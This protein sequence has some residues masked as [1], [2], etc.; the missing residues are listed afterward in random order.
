[1]VQWVLSLHFWYWN[2]DF[3]RLCLTYKCSLC[4]NGSKFQQP[5]F[6][7]KW[8]TKMKYQWTWWSCHFWYGLVYICCLYVCACA[9]AFMNH[10]RI[11]PC[12]VG[13]VTSLW[14]MLLK[15][16]GVSRPDSLM[17][18]IKLIAYKKEFCFIWKRDKWGGM[19]WPCTHEKV[20]TSLVWS[21]KPWALIALS[22]Q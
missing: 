21:G 16:R 12:S 11:I 15:D 4:L 20:N 10:L 18:A 6:K 8:E 14:I 22:G 1:M 5:S 9:W 13:M 3:H 17:A 2:I 7:K 19:V